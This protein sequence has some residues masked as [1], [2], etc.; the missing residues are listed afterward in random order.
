MLKTGV[1]SVRCGRVA[2]QP[3][4]ESL[5]Q[6]VPPGCSDTSACSFPHALPIT[7]VQHMTSGSRCSRPQYLGCAISGCGIKDA[8]VLDT[9]RWSAI[10]DPGPHPGDARRSYLPRFA[11]F[12]ER[13]G[14]DVVPVASQLS[15]D[16]KSVV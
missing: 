8:A 4:R 14:A 9:R 7:S 5:V 1:I 11:R 6:N 12:V 3:P 2:T 15:L 13:D 10:F 16:R